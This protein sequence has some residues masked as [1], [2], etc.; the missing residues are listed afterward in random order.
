MATLHHPRVAD[1]QQRIEVDHNPRPNEIAL[2]DYLS[3]VSRTA[4]ASFLVSAGHIRRRRS[5]G[6][7]CRAH[8]GGPLWRY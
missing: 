6:L 8:G 3:K 2:R 5:A 7:F 4:H 1:I